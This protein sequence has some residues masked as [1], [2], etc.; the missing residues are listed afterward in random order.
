MSIWAPAPI[1][2]TK[3]IKSHMNVRRILRGQPSCLR[4]NYHYILPEVYQVCDDFRNVY[5]LRIL[6]IH[7]LNVHAVLRKT[8]CRSETAQSVL[9]Q[10]HDRQRLEAK[11]SAE[12]NAPEN[13]EFTE[14]ESYTEEPVFAFKVDSSELSCNY[15]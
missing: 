10:I 15:K 12:E 9:D 11:L 14:I 1:K 2:F 7:T 5:D 8:M 6:L 3:K 4:N 13:T